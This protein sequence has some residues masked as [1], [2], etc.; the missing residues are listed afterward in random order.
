MRVFLILT[1]FAS[2]YSNVIENRFGNEWTYRPKDDFICDFIG[3]C[4]EENNPCSPDHWKFINY[5][6][7]SRCQTNQ[8]SPI[9]LESDKEYL[10]T[11]EPILFT[12][13]YCNGTIVQKNNTWE[14]DFVQD[15]KCSVSISNHTWSLHNFHI[16]NAEHTI[17]SE[18][19]PLEIHYVH[20]DSD[21]HLMV[22]ALFVSG[23][24]KMIYEPLLN[25]FR[26]NSTVSLN[27]IDPY[28]IIQEN[29]SYWNYQGSLTTP[30]CQV[31]NDSHVDWFVLKDDLEINHHQ[32]RYFTQYLE[33]VSKS[34][35]GRV[36]R[37]IQDILQ[38]TVITEY[39]HGSS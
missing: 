3:C 25:V 24:T 11:T 21:N 28:S 8:Q 18:Y 9:N 38:N 20:T 19:Y 7:F 22:M 12:Q 26:Q 32:I 13:P 17:N 4:G 10:K 27:R 33:H 15:E 14:V 36:S 16:H 34:Y 37:P 35:H 29:P 39:D 6:T 1:L 31:S 2:S 30:P 23:S 5:D